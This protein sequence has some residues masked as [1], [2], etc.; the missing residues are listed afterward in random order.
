M[1]LPH[2][3][4]LAVVATLLTLWG[5]PSALAQ[6]GS[7]IIP[8]IRPSSH[9][10][11]GTDFAYWDLFERPPGSVLNENYLYPNP[12]ALLLNAGGRDAGNN[13]TT[14]FYPRTSLIQTGTPT[15]FLTGSAAIYSFAEPL[16]FEVPYEADSTAVGEVT[17]V[18]FQTMSGGSGLKTSSMLISYEDMGGAAHTVAPIFRA[19]DDPQSGAFAQRTISAF[20]WNLTGLGIRSFKVL[21]EANGES[22]TLW[23]AQL[24]VVV[25]HSFTQQLGYYLQM[26]ARPL[27]RFGRPGH[28][29]LDAPPGTDGRFILPGANLTLNGMP[30]NQWVSV[31]WVRDGVVTAGSSYP[32]TMPASDVVVTALFAP[33]TYAAWR[34]RIFYHENGILGTPNDYT[35]DAVSAPAVDHDHDGLSNQMEY[36]F[37]CDPYTPDAGRAVQPMSTFVDVQE[38]PCITYR[39]NGAPLGQP[40]IPTYRVQL[41]SDLVNWADNGN[42]PGTTVT[43]SRILQADGSVLVT[44]RA[45]Q[46]V[47]SF[48]RCFMQVVVE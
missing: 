33:T 23:E 43:V 20:Q 2:I 17:N 12:P 3:C 15:A 41:S 35:N 6:S 18:I 26:P 13:P 39:T 9:S 31:G 19:H 27:V 1:R 10:D 40:G 25:G 32:L 45:T 30:E 4:S 24:D 44:E 21:F 48:S 34:S 7:F 29:S 16:V 22:M 37:G 11:G 14:A 5:E 38:Y 47:G 28:V 42:A 8:L 46:P 36:A